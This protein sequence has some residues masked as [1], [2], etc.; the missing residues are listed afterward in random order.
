MILAALLLRLAAAAGGLWL[1]VP[2]VHQ[3]K[4]G[5]GSA[6]VWM[7][8]QYWK[9]PAAPRL[10]EIHQTL[11]SKEAKGIYAR[12]MERYF[13]SRGFQ[14]FPF[15]GE[16]SDIS[17]HISK[18][19]PLIVCLERNAIGVPYHY[20]VVAGIDEDRQLVLIN[21]PADRKLLP[22]HRADFERQWSATGNWTLLALPENESTEANEA[23]VTSGSRPAADLDGLDL[24]DASAAFRA[25]DFAEA[26]ERLKSAL[27][28]DPANNFVNDFLG[29]TYL[30]DGNFEAALK[31]WNHAG[32]PKLRD[33]KVDPPVAFDPVRL[34]RTFAFSRAGVLKLDDYYE[35]RRRLDS[36]EVFPDYQ[37][38]LTPTDTED[39]DLTVH[40]VEKSGPQFLSWI[41]GLPYETVYPA[42]WNAGGRA[43]N[44]ESMV[45]WNPNLRRAFLSVSSPFGENARMGYRLQADGREEHWLNNGETF[46]LRRKE[47][48]GEIHGAAAGGWGWS[49]GA[50]ITQRTFTNAFD[51]GTSVSYKGSL[52]R[53]VFRIPERRLTLDSAA[54]VQVGKL[55]GATPSRF[56]KL[57]GDL[58]L[59]WF[60]VSRRKDDY[61]TS[62]RLRA[63][64]SAGQLP[65]DE[66]FILGLDRDSS[67]RLRGHPAIQS[68]QKGAAPIGSA[69]ALLNADFQKRL[70]GN[71]LFHFDAG[72]L[73]DAAHIS[74]QNGWLVDAGLQLRVSILKAFT[75]N[76]SLARGLR[77]GR[78]AFFVE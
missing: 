27:R 7:L 39:F 77:D 57:E 52:S 65:F 35:T 62:I 31:Y 56:A 53:N 4:N 19:R 72:P 69:Y 6:S 22:M 64:S 2:F 68:G 17:A 55:F 13:Q 5:C 11:F 76:V 34:D 46:I 36:L 60:P 61:E 30:L 63:G 71:A 49:T 12:D 8:L 50:V 18:G 20:V 54:D 16:W 23:S 44:V 1:D 3:E 70:Y 38:E 28:A 51:G 78:H 41:K 58:S 75:L 59:R 73:L 45:R 26:E 9:T 29:T 74:S 21:D 67:L 10:E 42:W 25:N 32:K 43:V 48:G 33:I 14:T 66:L 15:K 37:F 40:A 47:F 24:A